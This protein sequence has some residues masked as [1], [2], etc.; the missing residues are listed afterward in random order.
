MKKA[1]ST[2]ICKQECIPVGCVPAAHWPYARGGVCSRGDLFPGDGI[3]S[4]NEAD[5]P[6][7]QNDRQVSKYYLCHNFVAA[8]KYIFVSLAGR[9]G[10]FQNV[11]KLA[12]L[13]KK[14][15]KLKNQSCL[16][17]RFSTKSNRSWRNKSFF[18]N[19]TEEVLDLNILTNIF[20][21]WCERYGVEVVVISFQALQFHV[22]AGFFS[23]NFGVK[24]GV[25]GS[26]RKQQTERRKKR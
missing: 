7:E 23:P 9:Y 22:F 19:S 24:D 17:L 26:V 21:F 2:S 1:F 4:C 18:K 15:S 6:S 13:T 10:N 14:L 8:G 25:F 16:V 3:P 20:I 11:Y 12:K 5:P